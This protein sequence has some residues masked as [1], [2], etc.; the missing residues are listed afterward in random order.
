MNLFWADIRRQERKSYAE[1]IQDLERRTELHRYISHENPYQ[2]LLELIHSLMTGDPVELL[3]HDFSDKELAN[4]GI[5]PSAIE[6]C[7]PSRP[8][9]VADWQ[10][11]LQSIA[12]NGGRWRLALYTSGSTGTP[13]R[14]VHPL[15]NLTRNV[16]TGDRY[17]D[18]V[19]GHAYNVSHFAGLQV[20]FQAFFNGNPMINLYDCP[21]EDLSR[22]LTE[23]EVTH[24]SATPTFYRT[25]LPYIPREI[26][27][28]RQV[29]S[30]GEK[31]DTQLRQEIQR[32][33]PNARVLNIYASTEAGSL[34]VSRGERFQI[35][36]DLKGRIRVS[37][38][39]ELLIHRD[40][41]GEN[42]GDLL[43]GVWYPTGD[44]VE[45]GVGDEI[46]FLT[47]GNDLINVAGY[48]VN[49]LE[50]EDEI[51][52]VFGVVDVCVT[53]RRSR[54]TGNVLTAEVVKRAEMS[55]EELEEKI[56]FR[57]THTFQP[58][59][60]PRILRFVAEITKGRTGKKVR[61]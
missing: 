29:T 46:R 16:R 45:M 50:V 28:I 9:Q 1:L 11:L 37:S 54:I 48:N 35:G 14:I 40:L 25:V 19:W 23:Q 53:A 41:L 12:R 36:A 18:H 43:D 21:R 22:V 33:F 61:S 44:I 13:K 55:E 2:V 42:V 52:K 39:G 38:S 20:F 6:E 59:K 26:P 58:W 24:L 4:L 8:P 27:T 10:E 34:F 30:G 60:V 57:L 15:A 17:R 47:R 51:K 32:C 5:S 3:D 31:F 49:P 56:L 7:H